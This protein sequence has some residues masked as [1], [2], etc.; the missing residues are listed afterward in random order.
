MSSMAFVE[1]LRR[2]KP[3]AALAVALA[4]ALLAVFCPA[5]RADLIFSGS[6]SLSDNSGTQAATADFSLNGTILTVTLTNTSTSTDTGGNMV[7]T[8]LQF[9]TTNLSLE[10][11]PHLT[12]ESDGTQ[13]GAT[14]SNILDNSNPAPSL[15]AIG[16]NWALEATTAG[17]SQNSAITTTGVETPSQPPSSDY[18][19]KPT[20]NPLDGP[21]YGIASNSYGSD[22]GP[23]IL[24]QDTITFSLDAT[25]SFS[26][27]DL[28]K[29]VTFIFGTSSD[30]TKVTGTPTPGPSPV[31]E[32]ASV[33]LWGLMGIA[34]VIYARRKQRKA[35]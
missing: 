15:T 5:A 29:S 13:S 31:P 34:G 22:P 14:A 7:L 16:D 32:P 21:S 17:A 25:S 4:A 11:S 9:N 2:I 18:F 26:L 6:S 19:G 20:V 1:Q 27:S 24:A 8:E 33:T 30:F 10:L 12:T 28:G 35:A 23:F 3:R